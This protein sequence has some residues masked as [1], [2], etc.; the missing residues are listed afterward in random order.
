GHANLSGHAPY[1]AN[2]EMTAS[3]LSL[4]SLEI[5]LGDAKATIDLANDAGAVDYELHAQASS[6]ASPM[7]LEYAALAVDSKG[8]VERIGSTFPEIRHHTKVD[9]DRPGAGAVTARSLAV[10]VDS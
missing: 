4:P 1:A 7:P 5:A 6:L 3:R 8:R 10:M 9:F 2:A